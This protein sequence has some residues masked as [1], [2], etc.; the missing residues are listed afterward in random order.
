MIFSLAFIAAA[1][2]FA[3]PGSAPVLA[4]DWPTRT[5]KIVVA[6]ALAAVPI[7]RRGSS[8]SHC[9]RSSVSR[10]WSRTSRARAA[11]SAATRSRRA[12]GRLHAPD[13]EQRPRGLARDVKGATLRPGEGFP[14]GFARGTAGLVMVTAPE[15]PA[16]D[17]KGTI[18][19][20]KADPGKYN[21]GSAGVGTTQHF[22]GRAFQP[23][24][25]RQDHPFPIARRPPW[26]GAIVEGHQFLR[27][28]D[29]GRVRTNPRRHSQ[30][31]RGDLA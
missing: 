18:A 22:C 10:W 12:K 8:R 20:L 25:W 14:D 13:D 3:A 30:G 26:C 4:Q 17:V 2:G 11:S 21:F 16:N 15:F 6:S 29:P 19:L 31:D 27:R 1:I 24:G 5:I 28:V 9:R 23:D 7:S